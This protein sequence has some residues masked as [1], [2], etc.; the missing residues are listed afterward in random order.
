M[1][2][3]HFLLTLVLA[4]GA[5]STTFGQSLDALEKRADIE[6]AKPGGVS[7]KLDAYLQKGA[8]P[9][10][11]VVYVHGGGFEHGDRGSVAKHYVEPLIAVGFSMVSLDYRLAPKHLFPAAPDDVQ[12]GIAYIKKNARSLGIDPDKLVLLGESAGGMLASYAGA[13]YLPGNKVAAV[14]T[15]FGVH[16]LMLLSTEEPCTMDGR[17]FAIRYGR[18]KGGEAAFLGFE[19]VTP[20]DFNTLKD[21]STVAHVHKDMPPYLL[22]HGTRDFGV[23]FE[24]SVQLKQVMQLAGAECNLIPIVAGGHGG[25]DKP[26]DQHYKK[27]MVEWVLAHLER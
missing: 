1:V 14:V 20:E 10:P 22:I 18:V 3:V 25:W 15:F 11:A 16:D 27:T 12:A 2:R 6:F 7:M 21:A 23:P 4:I 8:G 26:E 17:E 5:V 24:Q 9:H 13:N 19:E